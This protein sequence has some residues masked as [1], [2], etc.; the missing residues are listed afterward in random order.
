MAQKQVEF[1]PKRLYWGAMT[2]LALVTT[3]V[4]MFTVDVSVGIGLYWLLQTVSFS[5]FWE[6]PDPGAVLVC[7][8]F[9][10]LCIAIVL[11]FGFVHLLFGVLVA[12]GLLVLPKVWDPINS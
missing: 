4:A 10:G 6:A 7:M 11:A 8:I 5:V 2:L 12:V 1:T 9:A 3:I